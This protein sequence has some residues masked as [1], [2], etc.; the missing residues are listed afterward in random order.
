MIGPYTIR[1]SQTGQSLTLQCIIMIDPATGWFELHT[2]D[3]KSA[4]EVA[5]LVEQT[6]L[7]RY[8]WP[9]EIVYDRGSE[10]MGDFANMISDDYGIT[11]RPITVRNPQT[12]SIIER[13][14]QT[15]GN[16]IRTFELHNEAD[17]TQDTW[18]GVLSAAMFALRATYHTTT[19]AT[20]MQLVFGRD[21]ILNVQFQADWKY[22]KDRKQ[23]LINS[24]NARENSNRIPYTYQVNQQ[25]MLDVTGTTKAKYA[26]NPYK[27]PYKVLKVNDNGTVVLQM[28]AIIDTVNI[29]NIKPFKE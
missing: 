7:S 18:K 11:K 27:G 2:T 22:I 6:W 17:V 25:V 1:N 12:N 8:P 24:N 4:M 19:Q 9:Q 23:K 14:H 3:G 5:N 26:Q 21:A 15:L 20:P 28:G 13:I 10:F 29:R 16:I